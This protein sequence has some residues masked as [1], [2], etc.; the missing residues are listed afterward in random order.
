[1]SDRSFPQRLAAVAVTLAAAALASGCATPDPS[2]E[3]SARCELAVSREAAGGQRIEEC[4]MWSL[5]PS[6]RQRYYSEQSRHLDP[7]LKQGATVQ[8]PW[9][10]PL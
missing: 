10:K 7:Y 4:R 6:A 2:T 1:M 8:W 5:T 9:S 3:A